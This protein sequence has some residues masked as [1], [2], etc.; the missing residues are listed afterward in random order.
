M[1][2]GREHATHVRTALPAAEPRL[3]LARAASDEEPI[4]RDVPAIGKSLGERTWWREPA[5]ET[6][7]PI[8]RNERD[9]VAVGPRQRVADESDQE[10]R[11][12]SAASLLPGRDERP[13]SS[14]VDENAACPPERQPATDALHAPLDGPGSRRPTAG[15]ACR[16]DAGEQSDARGTD[17]CARQKTDRAT[18]RCNER[19][20]THPSTVGPIVSHVCVDFVSAV[21]RTRGRCV[22]AVAQRAARRGPLRPARYL[23]APSPA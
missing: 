14:G 17:D 20:Q 2:P 23:R 4:R 21:C 1:S 13:R 18:R 10:L 6:T 7:L 8:A 19:E 11:Q 3:T 22:R 12:I 16:A 5:D 9:H 15:T